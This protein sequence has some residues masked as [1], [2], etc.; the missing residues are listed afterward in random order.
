ML[1]A[2]AADGSLRDGQSLPDKVITYCGT[3]IGGQGAEA[4]EVKRGDGL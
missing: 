3:G 4:G 2:R 1:L